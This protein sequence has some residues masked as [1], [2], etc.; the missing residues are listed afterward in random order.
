MKTIF[1]FFLVLCLAL[2]VAPA[3]SQAAGGDALSGIVLAQASP[4][5]QMM[6]GGQ[7]QGTQTQGT[8]MMQGGQAQGGAAGDPCLTSHQNC[9]AMCGGAANCVT[10]CNNGYAL[11]TQQNRGGAQSDPCM[12][13]YQRC[14]SMCAGAGNCV[15]NCNLGYAACQKNRGGGKPPKK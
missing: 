9:V 15:N 13:S 8:R 7:T 10:N 2:A 11:C 6:Q 5:G 14:V 12:G 3:T 1:G 4:G